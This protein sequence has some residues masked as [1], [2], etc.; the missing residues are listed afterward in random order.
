[1]LV[2]QTFELKTMC[3]FIKYL[4]KIVVSFQLYIENND[5]ELIGKIKTKCF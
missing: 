5:Y 4:M 3:M 1:M 2:F